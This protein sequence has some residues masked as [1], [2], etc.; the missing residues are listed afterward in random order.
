VSAPVSAAPL[1]E[2]ARRIEQAAIERYAARLRQYGADPRTLGWDTTGH[3]WTRFEAVTDLVDLHG[4]SVVDIG[5]GFAD[6]YAFL[7]ARSIRPTTYLGVDINP[8][9]L[10]VARGRFPT[11]RYERRNL[12]LEPY[13]D[14]VA[15]VGVML[16]L[17]NFRLDDVGN[18][19][20][21]AAML[22]AALGAVRRGL[23]VDFLSARRTPEYPAE[24]FVFYYEPERMLDLALSLTPEVVLKH[25]YPPIPQREFMLWLAKPPCVS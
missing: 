7:E 13:A 17:L 2:A 5:C 18:E 4:T 24:A 20:Y 16:G 1:R 22:R 21:A 12:L 14:P 6:L 9:L 10:E 8:H 25:D 19:D 15:D 23:V 3:Q 11:L